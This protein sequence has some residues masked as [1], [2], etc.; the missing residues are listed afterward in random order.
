[1]SIN[2]L[3]KTPKSLEICGFDQ[4]NLWFNPGV[5]LHFHPAS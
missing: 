1:M 5:R 3:W 2:K 4:F